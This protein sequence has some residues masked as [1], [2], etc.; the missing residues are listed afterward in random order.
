MNFTVN[1]EYI[2]PSNHVFVSYS[3][4]KLV[5]LSIRSHDDGQSWFGTRLHAFLMDHEFPVTLQHLVPFESIPAEITHEQL[6]RSIYEQPRG[7]GYVVEIIQPDQASYLVK[8]KTHKYLLVHRDGGDANSS[9]SLLEAILTENADDLK[10]LYQDDHETL[11]RIDEM[12]MRII[13]RYNQMLR[14]A[15]NFYQTNKTLSRKKY[16]EMLNSSQQKQIY[17]PLIIR[18]YDGE[19]NDYRSFAMKHAKEL[20]D[21]KLHD[22]SVMTVGE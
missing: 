9:R 4:S 20:F 14:W 22:T 1:M 16:I 2:S 12:E 5:V 15:E 6:L 17:A 7:E 10:A 19:E 3:E 11:K 21:I 13:P 18:L 8:I